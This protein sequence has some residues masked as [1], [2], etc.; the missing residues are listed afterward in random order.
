MNTHLEREVVRKWAD[1]NKS[2][3]HIKLSDVYKISEDI[4]NSRGGGAFVQLEAPLDS[5]YDYLLLTPDENNTQNRKGIWVCSIDREENLYE[6]SLPIDILTSSLLLERT[7]KRG[8]EH[9]EVYTLPAIIYAPLVASEIGEEGL[10]YI[11]LKKDQILTLFK[12][13]KAAF[14]NTVLSE[15][16]A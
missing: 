9:F 16:I 6:N 8:R 3:K 7:M 10:L 2:H 5:E 4:I 15:Y 14:L 12:G 11:T 1:G 13:I